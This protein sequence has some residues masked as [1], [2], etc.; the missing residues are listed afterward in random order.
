MEEASLAETGEVSANVQLELSTPLQTTELVFWRVTFC[1]SSPSS[2]R[3]RRDVAQTGY[4]TSWGPDPPGDQQAFSL[5]CLK[6]GG[7]AQPFSWGDAGQGGPRKTTKG[8]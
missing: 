5:R 6:G 7:Q 3:R 4:A 1:S 8:P 2:S